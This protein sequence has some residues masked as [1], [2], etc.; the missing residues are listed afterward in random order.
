MSKRVK[1][2]G[3]MQNTN[4]IIAVE[5]GKE[6]AVN[7]EMAKCDESDCYRANYLGQTPLHYAAEKG[8]LSMS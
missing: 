4:L 2:L 3:S 7:E 8:L 5:S 1:L 6:K